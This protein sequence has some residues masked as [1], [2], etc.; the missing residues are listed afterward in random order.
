MFTLTIALHEDYRAIMTRYVCHL[1]RQL[2]D[3][4]RTMGVAAPGFTP[5]EWASI[6]VQATLDDWQDDQAGKAQQRQSRAAGH[7]EDR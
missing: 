7:T 1:N 4:S 6:M 5:A 2:A 3:E